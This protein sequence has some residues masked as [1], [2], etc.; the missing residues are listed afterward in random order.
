MAVVIICLFEKHL[1]KIYYIGGTLIILF[2]VYIR[3]REL[4]NRN[5]GECHHI[6]LKT[7]TLKLL[8]VIVTLKLNEMRAFVY[9]YIVRYNTVT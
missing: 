2:N 8:H 7:I 9:Y 3:D 5:I 1:L 4:K 6:V